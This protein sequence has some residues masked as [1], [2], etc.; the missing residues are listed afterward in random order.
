MAYN[1]SF[2]CILLLGIREA[3][4]TIFHHDVSDDERNE[5][6]IRSPLLMEGPGSD[7][8][9]TCKK[10]KATEI[11]EIYTAALGKHSNWVEET[12]SFGKEEQFF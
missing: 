12:K 7:V 3:F 2:L 6:L 4:K 8:V 1:P 10:V 5:N 11:A 9:A